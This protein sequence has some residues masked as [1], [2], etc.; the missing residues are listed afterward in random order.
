MILVL[1]KNAIMIICKPYIRK[2]INFNMK[3]KAAGI[4]N[5]QIK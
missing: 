5:I 4:V 3:C 2:K 1:V